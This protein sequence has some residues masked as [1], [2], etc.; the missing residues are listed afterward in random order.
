MEKKNR[1]STAYWLLCIAG[2]VLFGV[3]SLKTN[4]WADEAYTFAMVRHSFADIW[5]ITAADVHPPLYYFLVKIFTF[6]FGYSQYSVR[7]FSGICY[8]LIPVIGG[9]QLTRLFDRKTGLLFMLLYMLFPFPLA[10]AT[11]A[12]MYSSASLAI[13]LCALFAYRAYSGGKVGDWIGFTAAGLCAAYQ[14][15]FALVAAGVIYGVLLV[16][17]LVKKRPLIKPWLIVSGVTI[18]LYLPWLKCF[19]EQLAFKV[20]NEYWIAPITL[21]SLCNDMIALLHANGSKTFPIFFGLLYFFLLIGIIRRRDAAPLLAMAVCLATEVLGVGVSLLI[22]P[23]YI[24]R[25]LVPCAPLMIF[26]LAW[27]LAR[28]TKEKLYGAAM[29]FLLAGFL[30]NLMYAAMDVLPQENQLTTAVLEE[31][32]DAQAYVILVD[33][34]SHISQIASYY[35]STTPIYLEETM[36]AAS[37]YENIFPLSEL[38]TEDLGTILV[39]TDEGTRPT[40]SYLTNFSSTLVG[41][42]LG[43]YNTFDIWKLTKETAPVEEKAEA[44]EA[45][46][47]SDNDDL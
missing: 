46:A 33:N 24:I 30:G 23:V 15:Y 25:Y 28:I 32:N 16:C 9:W 42:Y 17:I 35:N 10:Y 34:D 2:A 22:R 12:R 45:A 38:H 36:G 40:G 26:F 44:Q 29:G 41:T 7:L 27:G 19:I 43:G 13:F 31:N 14:H 11:E 21:E 3:L 6:P 8:L 37:P 5:R 1:V 47:P 18:V 39:F 4:V 20:N